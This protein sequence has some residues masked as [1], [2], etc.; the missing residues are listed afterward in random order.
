METIA[1]IKHKVHFML[2]SSSWAWRLPSTVV[3]IPR[4]SWIDQTAEYKEVTAYPR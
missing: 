1:Q 2:T 3:E 4:K